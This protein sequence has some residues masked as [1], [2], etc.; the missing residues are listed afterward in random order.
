MLSCAGLQSRQ[1]VLC[2][3]ADVLGEAGCSASEEELAAS[4]SDAVHANEQLLHRAA[5]RKPLS[6]LK[7]VQVTSA[8]EQTL[9]FVARINYMREYTGRTQTSLFVGHTVHVSMLWSD[10]TFLLTSSLGCPV[11]CSCTR[12]TIPCFCSLSI[13]PKPSPCWPCL[14]L[15]Q[16]L[17]APTALLAG[18][19]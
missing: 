7:C 4:L 3:A 12:H 6:I 19:Q 8:L 11:S 16:V 1:T 10:P 13:V 17:T 2:C 15:P 9:Y 14:Q 5:R 18:M